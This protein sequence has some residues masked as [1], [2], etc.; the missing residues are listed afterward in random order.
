VKLYFVKKRKREKAKE[1]VEKEKFKFVKTE[2][3]KFY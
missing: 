3:L 1:K 2:I